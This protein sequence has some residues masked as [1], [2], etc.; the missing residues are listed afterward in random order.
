[1]SDVIVSELGARWPRRQ[2]LE[3]APIVADFRIRGR[4]L[5]TLFGRPHKNL[6]FVCADDRRYAAP[7]YVL[8][9]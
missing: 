8:R 3:V 4:S 7:Q 1:M 6:A 9:T 5:A 2:S